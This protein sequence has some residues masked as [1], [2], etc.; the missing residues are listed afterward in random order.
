MN[1]KPPFLLTPNQRAARYK[2][3]QRSRSLSPWLI[4]G[5]LS[6]AYWAAQMALTHFVPWLQS[7]GK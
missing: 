4:L 1:T 2:R 5:C 3:E 6:A 7:F